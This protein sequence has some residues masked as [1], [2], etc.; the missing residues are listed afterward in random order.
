MSAT[1][2]HTAASNRAASDANAARVTP[3]MHW[4]FLI[5]I[6]LVFIAGVQLFVLGEFTNQFFAWTIAST[7]TAAT[8]GAAYWSTLPM[9]SISFRE[10]VWAHARI[11]VGGVWVFTTLTLL[12]TFFHWDKFHW[13][14]PLLTA[15]L[16]FYVWLAIYALVPIGVLV[17][18]F[19]QRRARGMDPARTLP[20]PAW[21]RILLGAQG[22]VLL[23]VGAGLFLASGAMISLWA[24]TLTPL[25]AMALGAWCIGIAVTNLQALVENDFTRLRGALL[26]YA[27]LGAL[28]L[29][30]V[31]RYFAQLN[32]HSAAAWLYLIFLVVILFSGTVGFFFAR[33]AAAL[34]QIAR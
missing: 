30:A 21:F 16:A 1:L 19:L 20:L 14:S 7:L 17:A 9:L 26:T 34:K 18:F 25:T 6:V 2:S 22:L 3:L 8:F 12:A 31:A 13:A 33:R 15:Q 4:W 28:Q 29:I 27:L 10:N 32:W 23:G 11:A 24:W 5:D